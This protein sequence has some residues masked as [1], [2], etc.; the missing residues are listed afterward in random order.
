GDLLRRQ[1]A[2]SSGPDRL[3]RRV[4]RTGDD[5]SGARPAR[6]AGRARLPCDLGDHCGRHLP[7]PQ[8]RRSRA[9]VAAGARFRARAR[10]RALTFPARL[11]P[12]A[13]WEPA[14]ADAVPIEARRGAFWK[15]LALG[16]FCALLWGV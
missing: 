15:G 6:V 12:G 3:A 9:A 14:L 11:A 7:Q 5:R 1:A 10:P 16:V 13:E 8:G 4:L 2:H